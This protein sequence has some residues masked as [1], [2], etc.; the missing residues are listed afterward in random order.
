MNSAGVLTRVAGTGVAGYSGDG[1]PALQAQL[2]DPRGLAFDPFGNLYIAEWRNQVVRKVT[3]GGTITTVAGIPCSYA[4]L[5]VGCGWSQGVDNAPATSV[6]LDGLNG[7]ATDSAGNLYFTDGA[8]IR[9]VDASGTITTVAAG[10]A[11]FGFQGVALDSAG[12]IYSSGEV[13]VSPSGTLQYVY[14]VS[15]GGVVTKTAEAQFVTN[16]AIDAADHL[17]LVTDVCC[18][19]RWNPDGTSS[20]VAGNE[21]AGFSGDGGPATKAG[22]SSPWGMAFD[23]SGNMYIA[24][25]GDMRVRRVT[26][27]G[28]IGTVAGNGTDAYS[29][30]GGPAAAAQVSAEAVTLDT[31]GNLYF[32]DAVNYVVRKVKP[33]GTIAAVAGMGGQ[34]GYSGD[35]GPATSALLS[36]PT[37]IASDAS[38]DLYIADANRI[39]KVTPDDTISTIAGDGTEGYSGDGGPATAAEIDARVIAVDAAGNVYVGGMGGS[40]RRIGGNG[41]ISTI[42]TDVAMGMTTAMAIDPSGDIFLAATLSQLPFSLRKITPNGT[43][44]TVA[45]Y[46]WRGRWGFEP[47]PGVP[48]SNLTT[49]ENGSMSPV[50]LFG[51]AFD[52][53]GNIYMTDGCAVFKLVT[54]GTV[55]KL[56]EACGSYSGEGGPASKASLLGANGIAVDSAGNILFADGPPGGVFGPEGSGAIRMLR[57]PETALL[58]IGATTLHA[59]TLHP[60]NRRQNS[61]ALFVN[62]GAPVRSASGA[63]TVTETPPDGVALISMAGAGWG[64]SGNTCTR[65]DSLGP[66]ASYPPIAVIVAGTPAA[67]EPNLALVSGGGSPDFSSQDY[68]YYYD[69]VPR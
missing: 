44:T 56:T 66:G 54:S 34:R 69:S 63:V 24:D 41:K 57:P 43:I 11:S 16:V 42:A 3:P 39:R 53:V 4:A 68:I 58:N 64:C 18:I 55:V 48:V 12:N 47:R 29:G 46:P 10:E 67:P 8:R 6:N 17:Y 20:I 33:D 45:G 65:S 13:Y 9:K 32:A 50:Y 25:S 49:F 5:G 15:P 26:P 51:L 52:R 30:D 62:N 1:G 37:A 31:Q 14:K 19:R 38:G 21:S 59:A 27:D 40:V 2:N 23:R 61:F 35:G 7:L 36:G 60:V 22:L 28:N